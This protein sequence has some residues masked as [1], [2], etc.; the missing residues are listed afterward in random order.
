MENHFPDGL[1]S[2]IEMHA[3]ISGNVQGVCFRAITRDF[4][5]QLNIKGI[6][7]NLTNGSVEIFAQGEKNTLEKLLEMLKVEYGSNIISINTTF[8]QAGKLFPDFKV[9]R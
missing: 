8:T 9:V 3:I 6:V 2:K 1:T 5:Q 7:K 4:A